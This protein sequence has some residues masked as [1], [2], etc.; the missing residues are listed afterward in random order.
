QLHVDGL[1]DGVTATCGRILAGKSVD[2]AIV[3]SAAADAKP[4]AGT[5]TIR[6]T[7]THPQG[8]G[9]PPLELSATATPYQEVYMPGGGRAHW[10]VSGHLV[11]VGAPSDIRSIALT[12]TDIRLKPGETK[13]IGV[14]ITRAEDAKANITLD[15]MYQHLSQIFANTLPEGVTIDAG[16][17]QTLLAGGASEGHIV[18]KAAKDAPPVEKQLTSLMANFAINFVMKATYSSPPVFISVDAA[19]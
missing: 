2:G 5:I 6:G 18:L 17:S 15:F 12:E 7:A 1:P 3:L 13:K 19:K 10:P 8:E 16:Q 9:Q 14:K 4:A 11:C